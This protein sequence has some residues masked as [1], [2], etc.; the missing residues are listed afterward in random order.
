MG[1]GVIEEQNIAIEIKT[2]IVTRG[3]LNT[4]TKNIWIVCHGYG[5]LARN[6]I[7]RLDALDSDEDFVL[8]L[9]GLS[10]FYLDDSYSFVGASWMTKVGREIELEN[11]V[12]YIQTALNHVFKGYDL[13][14]YTLNLLGFSQGVSTICRMAA[15]TKLQFDHLILWAGS[16]PPEL[17]SED[18][19]NISDKAKVFAVVGD[20]DTFIKDEQVDKEL[21][22]LK[23][24]FGSRAELIRF[25]GG[26]QVDRDTLQGL[27][28]RF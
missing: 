7:K 25:M 17:V 19:Q 20:E 16:F 14:N 28:S 15:A 11:Q 12:T 21:E 4:K 26:H 9:Q 5:Q 1:N 3:Q 13:N 22:K 2:P 10:K 18:F 6:F 24:A 8:G 23:G 27:I